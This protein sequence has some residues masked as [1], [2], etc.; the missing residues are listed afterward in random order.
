[1]MHVIPEKIV[2]WFTLV[3]SCQFLP[4]NVAVLVDVKICPEDLGF[5]WPREEWAAWMICRWQLRPLD[6]D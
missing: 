3:L 4:Q 5:S 1:M 2:G 6:K